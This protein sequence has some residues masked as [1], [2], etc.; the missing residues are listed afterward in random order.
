M[1]KK[2]YTIYYFLKP[3]LEDIVG[4]C[5]L[6][7]IINVLRQEDR[8]ELTDS[9]KIKY[10]IHACKPGKENKE[11]IAIIG[12]IFNHQSAENWHTD[13]KGNDTI[14]EEPRQVTVIVNEKF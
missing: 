4:K 6:K 7:D 9:G 13:S 10:S 14:D 2:Q 8:I 5:Y 3:V 11:S 12:I 1:D